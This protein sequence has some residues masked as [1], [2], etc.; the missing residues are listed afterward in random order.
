VQGERH[1]GAVQVEDMT[2]E[3]FTEALSKRQFAFRHRLFLAALEPGTGLLLSE[4]RLV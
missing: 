3:L 1:R 4:E 2:D